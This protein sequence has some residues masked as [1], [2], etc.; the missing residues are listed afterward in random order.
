MKNVYIKKSV[1]GYYISLDN[2]LPATAYEIG[3]TYQDFLAN[4]WV[5]LSAKQVKFHNDNPQASVKEVL[6]MQ[7]TPTPPRTLE[8]AK[9][10]KIAQIKA[11]D[12]SDNVNIFHV[13]MG[14]NTIDHWFTP[15][16]RS[17]FYSSIIAAENKGEASLQLY[18]G[19]IP[20][21][22]PTAVAKGMLSDVQLY[23]NAC[24]NV[25]KAHIIAVEA[26]ET[27]EA[28]D[29]YDNTTG[30]PERLVFNLNNE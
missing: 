16:I 9:S 22:L 1:K 30:Y 4:K 2:E 25:T 12:D 7:I 26:L 5:L 6:D 11:Y 27:I 10:E 13:V 23:A 18:I 3:T 24:A 17:D 19:E 29:A 8:Q 20:V 28:V 14:G 21:T 15:D